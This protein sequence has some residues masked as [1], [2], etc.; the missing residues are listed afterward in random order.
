ML[1]GIS[2]GIG[3]HLRCTAG[4]VFP[5]WMTLP[6][7]GVENPA[8]IGMALES[9]S[10]HIIDFAFVPVGRRPEIG[11]ALGNRFLPFNPTF[12]RRRE[13]GSKESR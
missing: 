10:E 13:G 3:C 4:V 2:M 8:Q 7:V 12:K 1:L 5:E 6:I 9:D 11:N